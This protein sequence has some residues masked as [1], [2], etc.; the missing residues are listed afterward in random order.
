MNSK[1][2]A[3]GIL[4]CVLVAAGVLLVGGKDARGDYVF[5][6]P[7]NLGPSIN[8][9]YGEA[10]PSVSYD[11][12]SLY[13]SDIPWNLRPG[14]NSGGDLWVTTRATTTAP[15][16]EAVNLGPTVNSSAAE[17]LPSISADGL[18]LFFASDRSGGSGHYDLWVTKRATT[19]DPWAPPVNLGPTVNST[20]CDA[21]P[22]ISADGLTLFFSSGYFESHRP[23][24][25]GE[26]DLWMTT[27]ETVS[28]PWQEPV[29]LGSTVNSVFWDGE[30]SISAGGL[31]LFLTSNPEGGDETHDILIT[32][33]ATTQDP[34]AEPVNLGSAVNS[35][36][37]DAS[38]NISPDGSTLFLCSTRPGGLGA[39]DLWEVP[40]TP[41]VDFNSD[42]A[43]DC[44]DIYDLLDHWGA[45][46]SLYDIGPTP[47]GDGVVDGQDLLVLA[48]HIVQSTPDVNDVND[49]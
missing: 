30:P 16:G 19:N 1:R 49:L 46:N 7:E 25:F 35:S 42:G 10:C 40:I 17:V 22:N 5:G 27:R 48:E 9:A 32:T 47:F 26:S 2:K 12:L 39:R 44:I 18:S 15:W 34:W 4:I 14:D 31:M 11:G 38:P 6:T 37:I 23:G 20:H 36:D 33:R 28:S 13:F 41:V 3:Q 29:N 8:T 45:D 24:G 43:I 21:A